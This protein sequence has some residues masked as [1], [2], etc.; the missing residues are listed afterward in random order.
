MQI[1]FLG[2][3]AAEGIPAINCQ[4]AHC[5]RARQE[6]GKLIRERN[7]V[8]FSFPGYELL[9]D[10]PPGIHRLLSKNNVQHLNGIFLTHEHFDHTSGIEEFLYWDQ[11]LDLF[12]TE[13]T[14]R[15]VVRESWGERLR[16]VAFHIQLRVGV[17]VWFDHYFFVPLLVNHSVPCVGLAI[18]ERGHK[19]I[20]TSDG[21]AFFTHYARTVMEK[22]DLLIVNT[23]FF[24]TPPG[25]YHIGVKEAIALKQDVKAKQ[26]ILTHINHYNRPHDELEAYVSQFEGVMVAYDGMSVEV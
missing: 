20:Y 26:L 15:R 16:D 7:A 5:M 3:G 6:G 4:C 17:P 1:R 12:A 10:T 23:P 22:A 18:Y 13:G 21:D 2:T 9:V 11:P 8:L 24:V 14:Y 19:V 25:E